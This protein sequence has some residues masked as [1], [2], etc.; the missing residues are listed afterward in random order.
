MCFSKKT[1]THTQPPKK[2]INTLLLSCSGLHMS[3]APPPTWWL[4]PHKE[5][6]VLEIIFTCA[7]MSIC[8]LLHIQY[9]KHLFAFVYVQLHRAG[10][11]FI[12]S[13]TSDTGDAWIFWLSGEYWMCLSWAFSSFEF[14]CQSL[15][16]KIHQVSKGSWLLSPACWARLAAYSH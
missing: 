3:T 5:P 6:F 16:P 11:T 9:N 12:M 4:Q 2:H 8:L 1:N 15:F 10:C 13:I 14:P 7:A